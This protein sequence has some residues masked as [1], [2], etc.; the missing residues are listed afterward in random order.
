MNANQTPSEQLKGRIC[1]VTGA[2]SGIGKETALGLARRGASVLAV[3]RD[4]SKGE[5]AVSEIKKASGSKSVSLFTADLTQM[6][7]MHT[8]QADIRE[9][10]GQ[11]HVLVNNAGAIFGERKTSED[12]V[13]LTF[14][15]NHLNYFIMS[16]LFLDLLK[17]GA[18]E[19]KQPSRIVNVA[20]EAHRQIRS[21]TI[22]WQFENSDYKPMFV[23]G[24]SKLANILFTRELALRLNP[25][26]IA[27]NCLHPGVVRTGFGTQN[28][29]GFLGVLFNAARPLFLTPE[30]GA[31]TSLYL[32]AELEGAKT[33]GAYFKN[34]REAK[35]SQLAF[36]EKMAKNLWET[37]VRLTGLGG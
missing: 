19:C 25:A 35:P 20:S 27:T 34:C 17:K 10:Y 7:E 2:N 9:K 4:R 11:L 36:N 28:D 8:L 21:E 1:L 15:T 37:S 32:A 26:E 16:H 29:W 23:Y 30:K 14:A 22:D 12:G 6:S 18:H 5:V 31:R 3:C 33:H 24:L 13:E